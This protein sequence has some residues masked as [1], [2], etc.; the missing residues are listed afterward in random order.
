MK[1]G[2]SEC[3]LMGSLCRRARGEETCMY[4]HSIQNA[5]S[6]E[7]TVCYAGDQDEA[8]DMQ[9]NANIGRANSLSIRH[10][11]TFGISNALHSAIKADTI[12]HPNLPSWSPWFATSSSQ[13]PA[14]TS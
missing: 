1:Q 10:L 11:C 6:L 13:T 9:S 4:E 14:H 7:D 5:G 2:W 3:R 12:K 8:K